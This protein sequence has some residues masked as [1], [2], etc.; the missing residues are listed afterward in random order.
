MNYYLKS[1]S[2]NVLCKI[3]QSV[4]SFVS[5]PLLLQH[6]GEEQYG[7]FLLAVTSNAY[8]YLLDLGINTGAVRYYTKW[9]REKKYEQ[10]YRVAGTSISFY[11]LIGIANAFILLAVAAWGGHLFNISAQQLPCLQIM[12]IYLAFLAI[13]N[14]ISTSF[15]QLLIASGNICF[16]NQ[17][18]CLVSLLNLLVVFLVLHYQIDVSLYLLLYSLPTALMCI[19]YFIFCRKKQLLC[20]LIPLFHWSEFKVILL[21][22]ISVFVLILFQM[23]A[24]NSRPIILAIFAPETTSIITQ[25]RI[26][27]ALPKMAVSL[28][29]GLTPIFL[30]KAGEV[31][32]DKNQGQLNNFIFENL[33][34]TSIICL[35]ICLPIAL[36]AKE[37]LIAYVGV[38]YTFLTSYLQSWILIYL[39]SLHSIPCNAV[40]LTKGNL[41]PIII[42]TAIACIMSIGLNI[43]LVRHWLLGGTIFAYFIYV[44]LVMG[45]NYVYYYP[46]IL[47]I[48]FHELIYMPLQMLLY[49]IFPSILIYLINPLSF[50][51]NMPNRFVL[52]AIVIAKSALFCL[53]YLSL[54]MLSKKINPTGRIIDNFRKFYK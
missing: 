39:L 22:S 28:L 51:V 34:K 53:L 33:K 9:L 21:Y 5:L 48:S 17:L 52:L 11:G 7:L 1:F 32:W 10:L 47:K 37:L 40:V 14:W 3:F 29:G 49:A 12:F 46:K 2:W 13:F 25:Y 38:E 42:V 26:T 41:R 16:I 43:V 20:S 50:F 36:S 27:E 45:F 35:C 31:V 4:V 18:Q 30:P 8:L 44:F 24:A 15:S 54:L 23:T 19:P 6:W